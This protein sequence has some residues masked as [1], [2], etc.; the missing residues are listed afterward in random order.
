MGQLR[1]EDGPWSDDTVTNTYSH[2]LPVKGSVGVTE[3]AAQ[4]FDQ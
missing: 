1:T 3:S 2:R 4:F